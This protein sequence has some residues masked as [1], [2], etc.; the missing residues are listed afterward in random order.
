MK[1]SLLI[2]LLMMFLAASAGA[3][4]VSIF[5]SSMYDDNSFSFREKRADMYH[6]IFGALSMDTQSDYTYVQGFYYG[7]VV[8]FRTFNERTYHVHT[9]GAYTQIQLNYRNN[10]DDEA[11]TPP[12]QTKPPAETDG[13]SASDNNGA[14]ESPTDDE[15][16]SDNDEDSEADEDTEEGEDSDDDEDSEADEDT[17]EGEDSDNDENS[18]TD[19]DTEEGEDSDTDENSETDEDSD[20]EEDS[21]TDEDSDVGEDS[22]DEEDSETDEDSVIVATEG[23][24]A[25][26]TAGMQASEIEAA[27]PQVFSDSLVSYLFIIPQA[28]GRFDQETWDFYDFQRASL[29]L[30]LRMH[31]FSGIM[32]R[33]HY[34]FQY[35]RYPNL[36]QFTH[37]ENLGGLLFNRPIGGGFEVF[38]GVDAGFKSYLETVNDTTWVDDKKSG[39]GK[40]GVKPPKAVISQFSTP[41]ATQY[42]LSAGVA[43]DLLPNA[44]LSLS[45]LRRSNP[46]NDARF[47]SEEALFGTS[48]DE[49]FDDHYGYQSHELR[50]QLEGALPGNIRT[51]NLIQFLDKRYPR[52]ATDMLGVPLPGAPQRRDLRLQMQFQMLYPLLRGDD[53]K[54]LSVGFTYAFVRNQSNNEYHDYNIHQIALMISADF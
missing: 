36:E 50:L 42:I 6:S 49:I 15:E 31:L 54:G 17:E 38:A 24:Q 8:L 22:V 45:Y 51:T 3:Q 41:S 21:E 13:D 4:S 12:E 39:K 1:R 53:G 20:D 29:L 40:G 19:E 37:I 47:I 35:K 52:T 2:A 33:P 16:D 11:P 46:A 26:G 10:D 44:E 9:L 25:E 5:T 48:E 43:W 30:R 34:T 28:G 14:A 32:M 23:G 7:A 18:E 27:A